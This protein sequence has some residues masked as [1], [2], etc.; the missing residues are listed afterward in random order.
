MY[1][2]FKYKKPLAKSKT[3]QSKKCQNLGFIL[4]AQKQK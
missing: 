1:Y 4:Y 2:K 3:F